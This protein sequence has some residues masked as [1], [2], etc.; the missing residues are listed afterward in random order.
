MAAG[1]WSF[2]DISSKSLG[3]AKTWLDFPDL[4][5]SSKYLLMT[6]NAFKGEDWAKRTAIVRVPIAPLIKGKV[7]AEK[8]VIKDLFNFRV[9]QN[10]TDVVYW[11]TH[12]TNSRMRVFAW[13]DGAAAPSSFDVDIPTWSEDSS[14]YKSQTPDGANWLERVDGRLVA[15][16]RSG[17]QLWFGWTAGAGGVNARPHPYVQ[18]AL[19]DPKKQ[20]LV[21]SI[22]LWEPDTATACPA[23]ATDGS[24]DVGI[25]YCTGG[26]KLHPTHVVG[27]VTGNR[28]NAV[29]FA[30]K[31]S[32]GDH[33]W[34]DYLAVRPA[35][36]SKNRLV[37]TGYTLQSG[38]GSNDATPSVTI[39]SR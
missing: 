8:I 16:T 5:V 19:V 14:T 21:D 32:P 3:L 24:G 20:E 27:Y 18:L 28:V 34:G 15:A 39:F 38:S 11:G 7:E 33:K 37:A 17:D 25:S 29:T 4:A 13:K 2:F 6:T 9:A 10:C 22:N 1:R 36:P 26:A 12:L 31:R 23:L 35:F 30:G